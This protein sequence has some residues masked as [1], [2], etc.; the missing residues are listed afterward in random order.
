MKR[1]LKK[2]SILICYLLSDIFFLLAYY[3][4][5]FAE[6]SFYD[7]SWKI[8]TIIGISGTGFFIFMIERNIDIIKR[9]KTSYAFTI[10]SVGLLIATILIDIVHI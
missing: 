8:A 5:I 2:K 7:Q 4:N 1:E 10:I 9:L 6:P 3:G